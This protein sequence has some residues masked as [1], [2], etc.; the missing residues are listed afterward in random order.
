M[1][2]E[3]VKFYWRI[4][5][6]PRVDYQTFTHSEHTKGKIIK[7]KKICISES[8]LALVIKMVIKVDTL[9]VVFN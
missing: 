6:K 1:I 9:L 7:G 2:R 3:N 4:S 5:L 8:L